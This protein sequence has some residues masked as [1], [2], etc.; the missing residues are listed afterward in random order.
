LTCNK[1]LAAKPEINSKPRIFNDVR[2]SLRSWGDTVHYGASARLTMVLTPATTLV[3]LT[4]F[5]ALDDEFVADSDSTELDL[6]RTHQLDL[7]HRLAQ[8]ITISITSHN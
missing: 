1:V 3:S 5:R 2:S 6:V 8:E 4:A 7:Q